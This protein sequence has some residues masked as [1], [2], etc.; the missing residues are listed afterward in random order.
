MEL[1]WQSSEHGVNEIQINESDA[2]HKSLSNMASIL[3][4]TTRSLDVA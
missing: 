3:A 1:E 2:S 4:S